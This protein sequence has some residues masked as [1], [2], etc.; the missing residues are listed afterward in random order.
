MHLE[1]VTEVFGAQYAATKKI[2]C[3][4]QIVAGT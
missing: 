2:Q 3:I 1:G 4:L